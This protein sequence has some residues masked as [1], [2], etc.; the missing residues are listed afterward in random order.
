ML[1]DGG[2]RAGMFRPGECKDGG[3][4]GG[5]KTGNLLLNCERFETLGVNEGDSPDV[6]KVQ[7]SQSFSHNVNIQ[8]KFESTLAFI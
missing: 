7:I 1:G 6:K 3:G 5:G 8:N 4:R 2:P